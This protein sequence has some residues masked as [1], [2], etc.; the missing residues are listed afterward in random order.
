KLNDF[1]ADSAVKDMRDVPDELLNT[2]QARVKKATLSGRR[3]FNRKSIAAELA[4]HKLPAYFLDFETISF[5][6]PI[7][8][9]VRPYQQIPFQ[10]S[11]HRL[12]RNWVASHDEFLDL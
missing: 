9:G 11:V 2:R 6:V 8:K 4:A 1:L 3:Y 7:W 5:A 10:F 12:D